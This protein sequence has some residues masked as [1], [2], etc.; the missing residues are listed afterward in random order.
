VCP[1]AS[2]LL[3]ESSEVKQSGMSR[4]ER[5]D[6]DRPFKLDPAILCSECR[7]LLN[8]FAEAVNEVMALHNRHLM[9]VIED[10]PNPHRFDLMIHAANERK[11]NAKYDYIH[12]REMHD[13]SQ[14][15]ET[16][17]DRT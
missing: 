13:C 4:V 14:N 17:R 3:L 12:H 16:N 8:A 11:Q 5:D 9:A 1:L 7:V 15:D 10:D 2:C 6:Q